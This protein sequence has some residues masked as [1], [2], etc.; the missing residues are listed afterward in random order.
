MV[1]APPNKTM[2]SPIAVRP[3]AFVCDVAIATISAK[4]AGFK[5]FSG[6]A[7]RVCGPEPYTVDTFSRQTLLR[8]LGALEIIAE[9]LDGMGVVCNRHTEFHFPQGDDN[10]D[11]GE[12]EDRS[13]IALSWGHGHKTD[14]LPL[15]RYTHNDWCRLW[16][17]TGGAGDTRKGNK[18]NGDGGRRCCIWCT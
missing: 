4:D 10:K 3:C 1:E 7:H 6:S 2:I 5:M 18:K 12:D 17:G 14:F 11:A 8:S 15:L 9:I 16:Q 13:K